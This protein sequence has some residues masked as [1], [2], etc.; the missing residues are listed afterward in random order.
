MPKKSKKSARKT[1]E[2]KPKKRKFSKTSKKFKTENKTRQKPEEESFKELEEI[3]S[4]QSDKENVQDDVFHDFN[5]FVEGFSPSVNRTSPSLQLSSSDIE[6]TAEQTDTPDNLEQDVSSS[7]VSGFTERDAGRNE[8]NL[9]KYTSAANEP[10]YG[11][12]EE[13]M[14][15]DEMTVRPQRLVDVQD[16]RG[17]FRNFRQLRPLQF[18]DPELKHIREMQT[19]GTSAEYLVE[20]GETFSP[21]KG[22]Q[23]MPFEHKE[24]RAEIKYKR[25]KE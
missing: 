21:T 7:D 9:A 12:T 10:K 24:E 8:E 1:S 19:T 3:S 16:F 13:T 23:E 18:E 5:S 4:E 25:I 22:M 11:F 17:G 6:Q 14:D 20:P 2:K 15:S